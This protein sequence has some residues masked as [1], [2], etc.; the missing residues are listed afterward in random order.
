MKKISTP[1]FALAV[2]L[3]S[4]CQKE[5][6]QLSFKSATNIKKCP[7]IQIVYEAPAG[8]DVLQF[9]YNSKG[10][11]T[12]ISRLLGGHTG[13][14]NF[15]FKYDEKNR[16]TDFIGPYDGNTVAESWHRYFY[17][18]K[19]NIIM[20]STYVFPT[21]SNGFPEN[22][23]TTR[24]TF[25]TYD[26]KGRIIKDSTVFANPAPAEVNY[27]SYDR[28]GNKTGSSY[29]DK[30]NIN[31]THDIWMFLNRDYS[32]NNPFTAET[33]NAADLP[34]RIDLSSKAATFQFL[35][36]DYSRSQINYAC[37]L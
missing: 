16:L 22:A 10:Y 9:S 14:P 12:R 30:V 25:Y 17:D 13:Y 3:F 18:H 11:P 27:Y 24:L 21:I 1:L 29:D 26:H 31:R 35:G 28:N 37:D 6:E 33:Y 5:D 23:F 20:D 7:I 19:G 34:T 2:T 8:R 4:S 36:N 32:V 15:A